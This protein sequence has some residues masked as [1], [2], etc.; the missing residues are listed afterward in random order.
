MFTFGVVRN[1]V[2]SFLVPRR[3]AAVLVQIQPQIRSIVAA[4]ALV[5][6]ADSSFS[7][8][9]IRIPVVESELRIVVRP[10]SVELRVED[11][12]K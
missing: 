6:D 5:L 8:T 7:R 4:A 3:A 1:C 11:F 9:V 12:L 10:E 2:A